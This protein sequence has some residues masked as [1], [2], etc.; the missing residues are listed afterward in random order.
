MVHQKVKNLHNQLILYKLH[1]IFS[2]IRD[3]LCTNKGMKA[4][5]S[6]RKTLLNTFKSSCIPSSLSLSLSTIQINASGTT[7]HVLSLPLLLSLFQLNINSLTHFCITHGM[8]NHL[9]KSHYNLIVK[10]VHTTFRFLK[11]S[12]VK[13]A[14]LVANQVKKHTFLDAFGIHIALQENTCSSLTNIFL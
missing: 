11:F 6:L 3:F 9:N 10:L 1:P 13:I 5:S 7:F 2:T 12:V 4:T 8:S 14:P